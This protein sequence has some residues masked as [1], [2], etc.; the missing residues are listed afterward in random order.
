[1]A[2]IRPLLGTLEH[3]E[4]SV[5]MT[6]GPSGPLS[7]VLAQRLALPAVYVAPPV[8]AGVGGPPADPVEPAQIPVDRLRAYFDASPGARLFGVVGHPLAHSLSPQIH[9]LWMA[10]QHRPGLYIPIEILSAEELATSLEPL[11]AD[12]LAGWNVTAP[13][14]EPALALATRR[15]TTA[16]RAGCAS[17]LVRAAQEWHAENFD[18]SALVRRLRELRTSGAWRSDRL[19]VVG[20]GGAARAALLAAEEL[21]VEADLLARNRARVATLAREFSARI[22]PS[23][24]GPA[25]LVVHTT[26]VG[27]VG[28]NAPPAGLDERVGPQTYLLDFVYRATIPVLRELAERRGARYEDGTR[29]LV[30]QA[31]ESFALF[32][33]SPPAPALEEEALREV[34]CTA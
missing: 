18:V 29:L 19:L 2:A 20:S 23:D 24:S 27:R 7:R 8:A 22:A 5:V 28:S 21:R 10:S 1:Y 16:Q 14:K 11:A 33:G 32:W 6:S 17:A 12:G 13:W 4:S 34:S 26:T 3:P 9:A 15:S 30:Y 31:A 25:D